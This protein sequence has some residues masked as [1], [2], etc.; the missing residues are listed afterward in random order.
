M[1]DFFRPTLEANRKELRGRTGTVKAFGAGA[2]YPQVWLR[3]SATLVPLARY[4]YPAEYLTSWIEEH[5]ANQG[6]DG[7]LDDW[8]AAGPPS[9]F[10]A[11]APRA[12]EVFRAG[13]AVLT[14]DKNTVE[15]D[16]ESSAVLGPARRSARWA[17]AAGCASPSP[18]SPW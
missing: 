13:A 12:R 5:L 14:A 10:V 4:H 7:G 8:I 15:A 17:T 18:A 11:D 3:D 16:Q 9:A 6:A 2:R 1:Q